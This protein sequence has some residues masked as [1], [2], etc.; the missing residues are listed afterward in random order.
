MLSGWQYIR[1]IHGDLQG[2]G[3]DRAEDKARAAIN[4]AEG[5]S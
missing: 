4:R 2:V 1:Q 3:W 5:R